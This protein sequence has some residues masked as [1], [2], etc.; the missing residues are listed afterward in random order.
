MGIFSTII[1]N[2]Y[3]SRNRFWGKYEYLNSL[4]NGYSDEVIFNFQL[5]RLQTLLSVNS[6]DAFPGANTFIKNAE[7]NLQQ[8]NAFYSSG[9]LDSDLY[10]TIIGIF[11]APLKKSKKYKSATG[12]IDTKMLL[13]DIELVKTSLASKGLA[14]LATIGRVEAWALRN[15]STMNNMKSYTQAK[16]DEAE[17]LV[18]N[19]VEQ[20]PLFQ[21]YKAIVTGQLRNKSGQIIQDVMTFSPQALSRSFG[22]GIYTASI[23]GSGIQEINS[24]ASLLTLMQSTPENHQITLSDDL[25]TALSAASA[26]SIQVKSGLDQPIITRAAKNA[27]SLQDLSSSIFTGLQ[28]IANIG[29]YFKSSFDSPELTSIANYQMGHIIGELLHINEMQNQLLF[30]EKGFETPYEWMK[31]HKGVLKLRKNITSISADFLTRS[32]AYRLRMGL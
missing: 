31:R 27:I 17:S 3:S 8:L 12:A 24:I 7:I 11:N 30:T 14:P 20:S 25:Y 23:K 21:N 6:G 5:S 15:A 19:I 18:A 29:N 4:D 26:L 10:S 13:A 28:E 9:Q 2:Q 16:S 1:N 32:R 22:S